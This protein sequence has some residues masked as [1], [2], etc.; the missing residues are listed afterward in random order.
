MFENSRKTLFSSLFY[1][2]LLSFAFSSLVLA[3]A[4]VSDRVETTR[5]SNDAEVANR[6][7]AI[8]LDASLLSSS[9]QYLFR[10]EETIN[11]LSGE[12]GEASLLS[13]AL[14]SFVSRSSR[15]IGASFY[16]LEG[17][18]GVGSYQIGGL[19]SRERLFA[20]PEVSSFLSNPEKEEMLLVRN[21]A[22]SAN[23]DLIS[24]P[25]ESGLLS[26]FK[27]GR[28]ATGSGLLVL[29]YD[30]VSLL[31][32]I[33]SYDGA[34]GSSLAYLGL[35]QGETLLSRPGSEE[36]PAAGASLLSSEVRDGVFLEASFSEAETI[37]SSF[38]VALVVL[39][40]F[41]FL[42]LGYGFVAKTFTR[43]VFD[44]LE[45]INRRMSSFEES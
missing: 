41:F 30:T 12:S 29:D 43:L 21:E 9:C 35:R 40:S 42:S 13:Q 45:E 36:T 1:P 20:L 19:V 39:L 10:E 14:T 6:T 2:V 37:L 18:S 44:P 24:Y 23:Y 34:S 5:R 27:K 32:D 17:L 16:P 15:L 3:T 28:T 22:I 25:A 33:L 8:R 4:L 38:V 31:D 26:L 7:S 11:Y